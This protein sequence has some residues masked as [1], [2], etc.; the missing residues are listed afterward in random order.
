[1]NHGHSNLDV[2]VPGKPRVFMHY[3]GFPAYVQQC[4]EVA[5]RG[6]EGFILS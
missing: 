2:V 6:Y 5:A 1:M 4:N 3:F